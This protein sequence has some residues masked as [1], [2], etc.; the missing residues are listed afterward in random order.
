MKTVEIIKNKRSFKYEKD[1]LIC[2]S[3]EKRI[4]EDEITFCLSGIRCP[5]CLGIY[6]MKDWLYNDDT[7]V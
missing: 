2:P 4:N 7:G 6:P 1:I 5:R 3:C